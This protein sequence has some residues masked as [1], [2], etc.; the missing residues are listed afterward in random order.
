MEREEKFAVK[1]HGVEYDVTVI[2]SEH[3]ER[4][5]LDFKIVSA[6]GGNYYLPVEL[7]RKRTRNGKATLTL[8]PD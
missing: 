5:E 2:P 7:P 6:S 1:V 4:D 8:I 3:P